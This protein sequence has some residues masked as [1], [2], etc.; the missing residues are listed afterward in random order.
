MELSSLANEGLKSG[1]DLMVR[2]KVNVCDSRYCAVVTTLGS[3]TSSG[4]TLIPGVSHWPTG[5][6]LLVRD[7]WSTGSL[8]HQGKKC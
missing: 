1:N 3:Y 7:R 6:D 4:T 8:G 2:P 5:G